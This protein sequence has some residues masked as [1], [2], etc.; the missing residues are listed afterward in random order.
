MTITYPIGTSSGLFTMGLFVG[1]IIGMVKG[2]EIS[3]EFAA[4]LTALNVGMVVGAYQLD[5]RL[6]NNG[7]SYQ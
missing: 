3:V 5:K 2:A 7:S 6:Q 1:V 4:W